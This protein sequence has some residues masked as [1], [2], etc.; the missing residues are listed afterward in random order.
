MPPHVLEG[1]LDSG[2]FVLAP[3]EAKTTSSVDLRTQAGQE[4]QELL[5]KSCSNVL[6]HPYPKEIDGFIYRKPFSI[7]AGDYLFDSG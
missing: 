6:P 7:L 1:A 3:V 4:F 2:R 5:S